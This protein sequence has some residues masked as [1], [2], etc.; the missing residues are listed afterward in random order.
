MTRSIYIA[1]LSLI[2]L[3]CDPEKPVP[4][5]DFDE[6]QLV[7]EGFF[8]DDTIQQELNVSLV[9]NIGDSTLVPVENFNLKLSTIS[10]QY[11]FDLIGGTKAV[12]Q[13]AFAGQEYGI[14]ELQFCYEGVCYKKDLEMPVKPIINSFEV[15]ATQ[16]DSTNVGN[17]ENLDVNL[18]VAKS[19]YV[20][21]ELF[22][23][24]TAG[25]DTAWELMQQPFYWVTEVVQGSYDYRLNERHL[26]HHKFTDLEGVMIK[27]YSLSDE[28]G[29]YLQRLQS[30]V[31]AEFTGSQYQ[32]PPYFYPGNVHGIVYGTSVDS[33]IFYF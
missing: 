31:Q 16:F 18:T 26:E 17:Q 30:F 21:Y 7:V 22:R 23:M 32:N 4:V 1:F 2:F 29:E 25:L 10:Q 8:T 13:T 9:N 11:P 19:Q 3:S 24:N 33:A 6:K 28:T 27:V 20:R 14:Y 5:S 12:S 15:T